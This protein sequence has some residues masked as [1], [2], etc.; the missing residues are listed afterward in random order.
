MN[1]QAFSQQL[2]AAG[3]S[4]L[5][6]T[7]PAGEHL[8]AHFHITEVGKVTKDFVDC[9]G[10]RRSQ[11][12]CVLQTLV[13]DDTD[14]RLTSDKLN[15]I[16]SL[17]DQL[18]IEIDAPVEFEIQGN[19]VQIFALDRCQHE[20]DQLTMVLAAKQTACLAPDKCG[21]GDTA[22][23]AENSCCGNSGCC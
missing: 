6:I 7:L 20:G 19:T 9:G 13:A 23:A 11:Q 8:A 18:D 3:S 21:I 12:T 22:P 10:I 2:V 5:Q 4:Q 16:V 14:H 15:K 1:L 17:A